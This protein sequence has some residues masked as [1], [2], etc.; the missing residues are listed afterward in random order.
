MPKRLA[1]SVAEA[2]SMLGVTRQHLYNMWG[3][4]QIRFT[5]LGG[6]TV[7]AVSELERILAEAV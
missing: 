6:R 1:Y 5:K 3:R 4:D 7:I 2:A